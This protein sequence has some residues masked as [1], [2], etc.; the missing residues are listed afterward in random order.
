MQT[1][2]TYR[3]SLSRKFTVAMA[4]VIT[5]TA[6]AL[7]FRTELTVHAVEGTKPVGANISDLAIANGFA[8]MI[9]AVTPAVVSLAVTKQTPANFNSNRPGRDFF[10]QFR[11]QAPDQIPEWFWDYFPRSRDQDEYQQPAPRRFSGVGAGVIFDPAGFIVTNYHVIEDAVDIRVTLNDGQILEAEVVGIDRWTDLA[12]LRV[13]AEAP[14]PYAEFG[15]TNQ[16][17]V[18]DWAIAIGDPF[19]L[20]KSAS[21][22][23]VSAMERNFMDDSPK[24][25]LLQIDAAVNRGNS[26]G[27]LFNSS[28]Q[29]IGINTMIISPT[30]ASAGVGFAVPA[31]VVQDIVSTIQ[32][33]G[34]VTRG[35]LGVGIQNITPQIAVALAINEDDARGALV[36][37]VEA[38]GPAENAGVEVGDIIVAFNGT[39]VD[40]IQTLSKTVKQTD[41]GSDVSISVL[42]GGDEVTLQGTIDRLMTGD[43]ENELAAVTDASKRQPSMGAT[44]AALTPNL[45]EKYRFD[46]SVQGV[47]VTDV[48][49]NSPADKAGLKEGDII[50]SINNNAVRSSR[51]VSEALR[52]I[53][54]SGNSSALL[55]IADGQG[56]QIFIV[57]GLS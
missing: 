16:V 18:G 4:I 42:R 3:N 39:P 38:D 30:G 21:L 36:S 12:V 5:L 8:E 53:E 40:D 28:G 46:S 48:E 51:D 41:P 52:S 17:R 43:P 32:K 33:E 26:G 56:E 45:R 25:P 24:V 55:L 10:R 6:A 9:D 54:E 27:P 49:M 23:I 34:R 15:D 35:W 57:V 14:I 22:G 44:F 29:V 19:G 37:S 11:F 7:L 47:V 31:S 20:S 2:R 50:V 1:L 13:A